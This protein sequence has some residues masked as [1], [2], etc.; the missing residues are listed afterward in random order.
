MNG[1]I[2]IY[3]KKDLTKS[4]LKQLLNKGLDTL[5]HRGGQTRYAYLLDQQLHYVAQPNDM[6]ALCTLPTEGDACLAIGSNSQQNDASH[7]SSY[8]EHLLF[9]DGRLF[10]K[11]EL[12]GFISTNETDLSDAE[13]V[14]R[15]I[16]IFGIYCLGWLK[17]YWSLV[18]L[19]VKNKTLYGARDHFGNRP[20]AF[21]NTGNHFALA[22]ES[23]TLYSL[24]EDVRN[25][26][27]NTII[28]QLLWGNIGVSDQYFFK[29]IHSIEPSHFVKYE[30]DSG[31]VSV[32]KYYTLMFDQNKT[33]Y[34]E[35]S[36]K[37]YTD[38]LHSFIT[39]TVQK[40]LSLIDGTLAFGVSG[41]LD[42]SILLC[43]AK[44]INPSRTYIAYTTTNN[45]DGGESLWAEKVV[46]H[47]EVDWVKVVCTAEHIIEKIET[48]NRVHSTPVYN[49]SSLAQFRMMEEIKKQGQ[50]VFIDGQ[51]GDEMFGGH[52]AYFPLFLQSLRRNGEWMRWWKEWMQVGNS[53]L[54]R[55]EMVMRRLKLWLKENYFNSRQLAKKYR[56][57]EYE[58]LIPMMLDAFFSQKP[59]VYQIRKELLN[60]ALFESHTIF[61]S[62]ILRWGE[63][64]AASQ[65]IECIMPFAN[66][67]DLTAFVFSIPSS[68][69]I[70]N[71]WNKY[72]L[73]KAMTN[74]IP[75]EIR[76]RKQKMGF[77]VPEQRWLNDIA[78]PVFDTIQKMED[79]E[80]CINKKFILENF[81][82]LYISKNPLYQQFIFRCYS[83]LL[84]RN[85]LKN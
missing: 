37:E 66:D 3:N 47:T 7:I 11:T 19:D 56:K 60:D 82:R 38:K 58:S 80:E 78:K 63:H 27:Q 2:A 30:M 49:P 41:G 18:Y 54:T 33:C 23:R 71:G 59:P 28:G 52:P 17:G 62:N 24:F 29:D 36:E 4:N 20:L 14:I 31:R 35:A 12:Y 39:D 48:L 81:S 68:Y 79:P 72:L 51:G 6:K 32:E 9:F 8:N 45:Y 55:K 16:D 1:L 34:N 46:R 67:T 75:D 13:I 50:V 15:I 64:S 57:H 42:S 40:N 5:A 21:C 84:W 65:G 61:L 53:G 43:M 85:G 25:I 26:N 83:Y 44:K 70:H 10:N 69:K 74:I 73:R 77:Y 22:S 76:L